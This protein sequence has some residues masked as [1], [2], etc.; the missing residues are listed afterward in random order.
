MSVDSAVSSKSIKEIV[1]KINATNLENK[2]DL[3]NNI[4]SAKEKYDNAGT[5]AAK[6]ELYNIIPLE[7]KT[8]SQTI[9]DILNNF[10]G[11]AG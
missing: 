9:K 11:Y 4:L 7:F 6:L 8:K 3:V 1:N 5:E 10:S 2:E